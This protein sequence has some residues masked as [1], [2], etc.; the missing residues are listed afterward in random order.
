MISKK[1][2]I[3]SEISSSFLNSLTCDNAIKANKF[4]NDFNNSLLLDNVS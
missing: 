3:Q 4:C 2:A 1:K